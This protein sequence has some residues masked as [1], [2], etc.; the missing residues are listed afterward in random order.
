M[1]TLPGRTPRPEHVANIRAQRTDTPVLPPTYEAFLGLDYSI[2]LRV[3]T[4]STT[5]RVWLVFDAAG[6]PVGHLRVP[7]TM[8]IRAASLRQLWAIEDDA[9]GVPSVV[10]YAV[11]GRE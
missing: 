9:D 11:G 8:S 2:W 1:E 10:R 5:E 7:R 3:R 6:N 4:A